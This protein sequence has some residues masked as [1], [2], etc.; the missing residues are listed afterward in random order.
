MAMATTTMTMTKT[1]TVLFFI[2]HWYSFFLFTSVVVSQPPLNSVE[3]ESVYRVL[4]SVNSDVPWRSLFSEDLCASPPHGVVCDYFTDQTGVSAAHITELSFGYVSDYSPNP[5][6]S[7]SAVLDSSLFSHFRHLTKLFF[8][9]CF[10]ET[11]VVF[12]DFSFLGSSLQELVFIENPSL[13]GDLGSRIGN[14]TRLRTLVITGTNVSASIPD[15]LGGLLNL[16]QLT[17]SRNKFVGEVSVNFNNLKK[18]KVLDLSQNGFEGNVPESLG[19]GLKELLKLDLSVN[20]FSGRIPGSL[21]GLKRVEFLDLSYNGLGK[22]GVPLF[23]GE[24]P[25]LKEVYLS[26]N[27]L[28]G[29]IPE[30]WENL[31]GILGIGLSETGL[32]GNIPASMGKYLRNACYLGLDNNN[33]EGTV[34]EEFG[35]LDSVS[36]LNLKNNNLSGKVP[37]SVQFLGKIGNK[38]KLEGNPKLCVDEELRN[39]KVGSKLGEMKMCDKP[40]IPQSALLLFQPQGSSSH[41]TFASQSLMFIIIALWLLLSSL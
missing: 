3:Q 29:K 12:P 28:G 23:L 40:D 10:T 25:S 38:L 39:V 2:L 26:G 41:Q 37:F 13:V 19:N 22:Y 35:L 4:E 33:L 31:G 34:P 1:K 9:R 14:L 18:L 27:M 8:Y 21:K 20:K 15:E 36:E 24:M 32:V 5:S 11:T 17:L 6:C 16:E 30:I 7:S